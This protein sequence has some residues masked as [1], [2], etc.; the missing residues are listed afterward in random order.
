M[1]QLAG[2]L[3]QKKCGLSSSKLEKSALVVGP[4]FPQYT[5]RY[6]QNKLLVRLLS[7]RRRAK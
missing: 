7:K 4:D 3:E 2:S 1:S 5:F 6:L